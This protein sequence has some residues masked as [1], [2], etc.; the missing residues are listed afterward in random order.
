MEKLYTSTTFLKMAGGKMHSNAYPSSYSPVSAH[1]HKL[2]KPSK[3]SGIFQ[4]LGTISFVPFYEKV[5]SKGGP[6]HNAP[7]NTLLLAANNEIRFCLFLISLLKVNKLM[8]ANS[9]KQRSS[10]LWYRYPC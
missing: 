5:E 4:S 1:G 9:S 8:R 6:W 7:L 3:K 2:R 10:A